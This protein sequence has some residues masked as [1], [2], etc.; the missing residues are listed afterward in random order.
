MQVV[1]GMV[2]R[3]RWQV[4]GAKIP[5]TRNS[6]LDQSGAKIYPGHQQLHQQYRIAIN[7]TWLVLV[8]ALGPAIQRKPITTGRE[9]KNGEVVNAEHLI[10][11]KMTKAPYQP[12]IK[13]N[14]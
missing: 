4:V 13:N 6:Q 3:Q 14:Q 7:K 11:V 9:R 1:E 2:D 10:V 12:L 8:L 5:E